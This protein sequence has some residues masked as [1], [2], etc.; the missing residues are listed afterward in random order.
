AEIDAPIVHVN[1]CHPFLSALIEM[2]AHFTGLIGRIKALILHIFAMRD[3]AQI[4]PFIVMP[5]MVNMVNVSSRPR[6]SHVQEGKPVHLVSGQVDHAG[7]MAAAVIY[8]KT[9]TDATPAAANPV[10]ENARIGTIVQN[11][12]ESFLGKTRIVFSHLITLFSHLVRGL[13]L[14]TPVPRTIS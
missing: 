6:T 8:A 12:L 2:N 5:V 7:Q 14:R 4:D 9:S 13:V 10:G 1:V 3:N 11:F